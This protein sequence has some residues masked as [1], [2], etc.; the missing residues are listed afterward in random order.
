MQQE[1]QTA[2]KPAAPARKST[3]LTVY[4]C[5]VNVAQITRHLVPKKGVTAPEIAVL[6][7]LHGNDAISDVEEGVPNKKNPFMADQEIARLADKYGK[8]VCKHVFGA[9][10]RNAIPETIEDLPAE[11]DRFGGSAAPEQVAA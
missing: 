5:V 8:G 7:A 3:P 10:F 9:G 2:A 11:I 4:D 1:A 6:K